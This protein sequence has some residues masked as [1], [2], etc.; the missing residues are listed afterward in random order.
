MRPGVLR[1]RAR[2][3]ALLHVFP[4]LPFRSEPA[5]Q[6]EPDRMLS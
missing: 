4:S 3:L 1:L 2:R 5:P 6:P